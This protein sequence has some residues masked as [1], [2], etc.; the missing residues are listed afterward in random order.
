MRFAALDSHRFR[1]PDSVLSLR[2]P[3]GI[4]QSFLENVRLRLIRFDVVLAIIIAV[5]SRDC[6]SCRCLACYDYKF[7]E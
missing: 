7:T 1:S 4:E 5:S 2:S 6:E 3:R